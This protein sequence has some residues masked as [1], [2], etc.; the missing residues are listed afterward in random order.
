MTESGQGQGQ[1]QGQGQGQGSGP[2]NGG[3]SGGSNGGGGVGGSNGSGSS[4]SSGSNGGNGGGG[5]TGPH[6]HGHPHAQSHVQAQ[7]Q[8]AA[9]A[10]HAHAQAQA[11]AGVNSVN[12]Y[13]NAAFANGSMYNLQALQSLSALGVLGPNMNSGHG[14][15]LNGNNMSGMQQ[16]QQQNNM[17]LQ[18]HQQHQQAHQLNQNSLKHEQ[19]GNQH[20]SS[21][22]G[23]LKGP[24][25]ASITSDSS[26]T[27]S[28]ASNSNNNN[29]NNNNNQM[30]S[31]LAAHQQA[32]MH[33]HQQAQIQAI[34]DQTQQQQHMQNTQNT[35]N[36]MRP[37]LELNFPTQQRTPRGIAIQASQQG[38]PVPI[39]MLT[40]G[41][42]HALLRER[43]GSSPTYDDE[44]ETPFDAIEIGKAAIG[45]SSRLAAEAAAAR[46][47][48]LDLYAEPGL[49]EARLSTAYALV[50]L[51]LFPHPKAD[52]FRV[53]YADLLKVLSHSMNVQ[54]PKPRGLNGKSQRQQ[55]EYQ[56]M[57]LQRRRKRPR[58]DIEPIDTSHHYTGSIRALFQ[59]FRVYHATGEFSVRDIIEQLTGEVDSSNLNRR[60]K[61]YRRKYPE[62][63]R[64]FRAVQLNNQG[65]F[66]DV[67]GFRGV[68]RMLLT[69]PSKRADAFRIKI[70]D[71]LFEN[72][73][74]KGE[75]FLIDILER[76]THRS[77]ASDD[78]SD[79]ANTSSQPNSPV[80]QMPSVNM[81]QANT[82]PPLPPPA[83]SPSLNTLNSSQ[84]M[85]QG[86]NANK[87]MPNGVPI[88]ALIK[89]CDASQN[90]QRGASGGRG[91]TDV[92][93]S[94]NKASVEGQEFDVDFIYGPEASHVQIIERSFKPLA[95]ALAEGVSAS[96]IVLGSYGSEKS[97]IVEKLLPAMTRELFAALHHNSASSSSAP[98]AGTGGG[99]GAH[100]HTSFNV[101]LQAYEIC[102]EVIQ[103]MFNA[104]N[105]DLAIVH[106][107]VDGH[108]VSQCSTRGPYRNADDV[109]DI[110]VDSFNCRSA[111]MTDFGPASRHTSTIWQFDIEQHLHRRKLR[112]RL[113]VVEAAA[114]NKLAEDRSVVRA[115][116]GPTLGKSIMTLQSVAEALERDEQD[117]A[118]FS[119][120]KLTQLLENGLAGNSISLCLAVI[121]QGEG[122]VS[123]AALQLVELLRHGATYPTI[124][125]ERVQGL[126]RRY[127]LQINRLRD[128]L[129]IVAG[130]GGARAYVNSASRSDGDAQDFAV[131][132]HELEGRVVRDNLEKLRIKEEKE[133][134]YAKLVEFREKYNALVEQKSSIQASSIKGEEEK[135]KISKALLD[136]RIEN[137]KLVERA[138]AEK[139]ELVTKLLN[140]ENEVLQH[141]MR[142]EAH[143]KSTT[144]LKQQLQDATRKVETTAS[145]LVQL[146]D[147]YA[148]IEA[149][150]KEEIAKNEELG[151]ELLTL[152][153]QKNALLKEAEELRKERAALSDQAKDANARMAKLAAEKTSLDEALTQARQNADDLKAQALKVQLEMQRKQV[154][155]ET[156]SLDLEKNAADYARERDSEVTQLKTRL[157]S[158]LKRNETQREHLDAEAR[159]LRAAFKASARNIKDLESQLAEKTD[160]ASLLRTENAQLAA[161][162]A[163]I[164]DD[165]RA[166]LLEQ[167]SHGT[168]HD[169]TISRS[170]SSLLDAADRERETLQNELVHTFKTRE[171]ELEKRLRAL[172]QTNQRIVEKNRKLFSRY[173]ALRHKLQDMEV[174]V[175]KV[176]AII[177]AANAEDADLKVESSQIEDQLRA[178][179]ADSKQRLEKS[180]AD[181]QHAQEKNIGLAA[182]VKRLHREH[183]ARL[184][185]L[186]TEIKMLERQKANL[187]D[188][189]QS[190]AQR[191]GA[192]NS[193]ADAEAAKRMQ[194][195][196]E[197]LLEKIKEL[198]ASQPQDA[199]SHHRPEPIRSPRG[200]SSARVNDLEKANRDLQ[201]QV[202]RYKRQLDKS[203]RVSSPFPPGPDEEELRRLREENEHLRKLHVRQ[204][205]PTSQ[206]GS[207][208]YVSP[209][210]EPAPP[211]SGRQ[212]ADLLTRA[213]VAEEELANYKNYIKDALARSQ[214][215]IKK[216]KEERDMW[217]QRAQASG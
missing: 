81:S 50:M 168:D 28:S 135:L 55:Q 123:A 92:R 70:A 167:L 177:S 103:D 161:K 29:N 121:R 102:D 157:E 86:V 31:S 182:S 38:V 21:R 186:Q 198:Q 111:G 136:L 62:V 175:D 149:Q 173:T 110:L 80:Q 138:E 164:T 109:L 10:A 60:V 193:S 129:S 24:T 187:E 194:D 185:D 152:V 150:F 94:K 76:E 144:A 36:G 47:R 51:Q 122:Q 151:V 58:A 214:K 26:R 117:F 200:V 120:S 45:F 199:R 57:Q 131:K 12:P 14:P 4:G 1:A 146:K 108:V 192:S 46:T 32:Q 211:L 3:S 127:R 189:N 159:E 96:I 84:R 95:K 63:A 176:E 188:E 2:N 89:V 11:R 178:E 217:R 169:D 162:I 41:S 5:G 71:Y 39:A 13:A 116:E 118:L 174:D 8:A 88:Q 65:S 132:I 105:R 134:I 59:K 183:E 77:N 119:E 158:E 7:A 179:L 42:L 83:S 143:E 73:G 128:E 27:T 140:A 79:A 210:H 104:E 203:R 190:L 99:I 216:L 53:K 90:A 213:T 184:S 125:D 204:S 205:S 49:D 43:L 112:S 35:F 195:I 54:I 154:D 40:Q 91:P 166:K 6:G 93:F 25:A 101:R 33:A 17:R 130:R 171:V 67:V 97:A 78:P 15:M 19:H 172:Q 9:A 170:S 74:D 75:D 56:Q 207:R 201:E 30:S 69:I 100:S 114:V 142:Q 85:P 61:W 139:Y 44:S 215:E 20:P 181:L 206:R 180:A 155:F 87:A 106:D 126:L 209:M 145:D 160:E 208:G 48:F 212:H 165:Y 68:V 113:L 23:P 147:S 107:P 141:E 115:R 16:Q 133:K 98:N 153:N 64:D 72:H 137:N 202:D 124:N 22:P 196:Q 18:P 34:H 82:Q 37:P 191:S 52:E 156:R 197:T 148:R 163:T 66:T